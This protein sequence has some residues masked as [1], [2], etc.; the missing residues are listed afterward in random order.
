M[1]HDVRIIPIDGRPHLGSNVQQLAGDSRG[2]WEGQTLVID[3]TN[4]TGDTNFRGA[5]Q[6]TRQD[7]FASPTLHVVERLTRI[8]ED[9]IRYQFTVED[10][11]TWTKSWSGEATIRK[12]EGPIFEYACHEGNYGLANI[13]RAARVQEAQ[14]SALKAP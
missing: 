7:I 11:A 10:L 6:T 2:H 3:T 5:P 14:E 12:V 4:F 13:L 9:T 8:D 1:M